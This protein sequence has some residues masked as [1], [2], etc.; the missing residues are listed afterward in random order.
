M[1]NVYVAMSADIIHHGHLN[2]IN[3]AKKLGTV[4]VGLLTDEAIA[5]YK[6]L[7]YI[8]FDQRK[9]MVENIKG[10]SKVIAQD[11]LDYTTNLRLIKPDYVV[12][13]DDWKTGIQKNVRKNVLKV[14]CEWGGEL[15]EPSYTKGISS[16]MIINSLREKGTTPEKRMKSFNRLLNTK[17]LVRLM[18]A[19]NG[20]TGLIIEKT[21]VEKN[22][23]KIEFDGS[24]LSSLTLSTSK[25][26]PDT[27]LVDF[28]SRFQSIEEILEVTSKPMIVDGD[29]GGKTEHFRFTVK[30]LERLG[31]SGVIIEDK[32]GDKRNSLFGDDIFQ[33]QD[34]IENFCEKIKQANSSL[35]TEDFMIIAR[36]ESLILNKGIDDA[37]NRAF[38]YIDAGAKGIMIHSKKS[39]GEEI[40][41]F[42][43]LFRKKVLST[44]L[45][46]VPSTFSHMTEDELSKIGVNV[47]IY[48]NHLIRSSYPA[49]VKTAKSILKHSRSKEASEKHCMSIKDILTLVPE[50]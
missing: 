26:K 36:V 48:G 29:T 7:T 44:P 6:R 17:P 27:E 24:W 15:I 35:V 22:N 32:K 9:L 18:E 30:T 38:N 1:K 19:H 43:K 14:L 13:G 2:I 34:S 47:V 8:P 37:L 11:T 28:S 33:E 49:M 20:L 4:T 25:G 31:V 5:S 46:V 3:T 12:H 39:D 23:K 16:T 40:I 21:F 41:E 10:V 50:K 45:I 42:C